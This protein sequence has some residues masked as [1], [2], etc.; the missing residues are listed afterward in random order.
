MDKQAFIHHFN[1]LNRRDFIPE[2]FKV[3]LLL[4][5]PYPIGFGQT[6]SQPSLIQQMILILDP[7]PTDTVLEIGT[8]SGY[9]TALLSPFVSRIY[10][11]ELT[12]VV[13]LFVKI[14]LDRECLII[15]QL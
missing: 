6:T 1:H 3:E 15:I 13:K 4:D 10:S 8:G 11:V 5:T 12:M 9:L 2:P 7:E 14:L